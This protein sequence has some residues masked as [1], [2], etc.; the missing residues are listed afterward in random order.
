MAEPGTIDERPVGL[1][2]DTDHQLDV[3]RTLPCSLEEA[4]D[5]LT[6]DAG[7]RVWLDTQKA[8]GADRGARFK[9]RDGTKGQ[10]LSY[11]VCDRIR[12]TWRPKKRDAD[13]T[14]QVSVHQE[15]DGT[16]LRFHQEHLNDDEELR[17]M[18]GHWRDVLDR[19]HELVAARKASPQ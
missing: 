19:L 11:R 13:T 16:T 3:Q 5:L 4:W 1:T 12:L 14:L 9:T 18:H 10:I 15:P 2:G 8:P 6:S 7:T 17:M